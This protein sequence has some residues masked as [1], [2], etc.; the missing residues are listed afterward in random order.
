MIMFTVS[1]TWNVREKCFTV[2]EGGIEK[3]RQGVEKLFGKKFSVDVTALGCTPRSTY[4][5]TERE[6]GTQTI[7]RIKKIAVGP[8]VLHSSVPIIAIRG[9]EK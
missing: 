7:L 2:K 1:L 5:T 8:S 9:A 4:S 3:K 6:E